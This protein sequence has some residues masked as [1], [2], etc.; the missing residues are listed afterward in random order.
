MEDSQDREGENVVKNVSR[1]F[2]STDYFTV[3]R[4]SFWIQYGNIWRSH[5]AL[6]IHGFES[7]DDFLAPL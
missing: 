3:R 1:G 2:S 4:G 6:D 7:F 5:S